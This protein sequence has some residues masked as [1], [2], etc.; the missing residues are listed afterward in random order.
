MRPRRPRR[1][2]RR[3]FHAFLRARRERSRAMIPA[4]ATKLA[5]ATAAACTAISPPALRA[6]GTEPGSC[7]TGV[8]STISVSGSG[9]RRSYPRRVEHPCI[10]RPGGGHVIGEAALEHAVALDDL[11]VH[12][13]HGP[14][15]GDV[16]LEDPAHL[17]MRDALDLGEVE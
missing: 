17:A 15:H 12:R 7:R 11:A 9:T 14:V 6:T 8:A 2:R 16:R 10:G 4:P 13:L 1:P 3:S 5:P